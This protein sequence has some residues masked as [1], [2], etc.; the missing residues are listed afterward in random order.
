MANGHLLLI[1]KIHHLMLSFS[2]FFLI[3]LFPDLVWNMDPNDLE[4]FDD[5]MLSRYFRHTTMDENA[6]S[7]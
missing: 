2:F 5:I 4:N 7:F 1:L 6:V 3:S